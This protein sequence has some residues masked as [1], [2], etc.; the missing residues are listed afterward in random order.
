[1]PHS[2]AADAEERERENST[3]AR[4]FEAHV[5]GTKCSACERGRTG[6]VAAAV[7]CLLSDIHNAK[8]RRK[9]NEVISCRRQPFF[10]D[11]THQFFVAF[12]DLILHS[13][14]HPANRVTTNMLQMQTLH[15]DQH[16]NRHP[17][18]AT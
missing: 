17:E 15:L 18:L 1:M 12:G 9:F 13:V 5:N 8:F 10:I 14:L 11:R 6:S 3:A 4:Q 7:R 2:L 16:V